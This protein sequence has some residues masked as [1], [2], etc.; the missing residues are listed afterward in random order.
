MHLD[1]NQLLLR[2]DSRGEPINRG[3]IGDKQLYKSF[4]L[5]KTESFR[6]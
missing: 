6:N 1:T 5:Q 2:L 4:D 3:I